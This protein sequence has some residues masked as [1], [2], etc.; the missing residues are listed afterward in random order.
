M[1]GFEGNT[2]DQG[3]SK[4]A[5]DAFRGV[6]CPALDRFS[7]GLEDQGG[8]GFPLPRSL[9]AR[10]VKER[11]GQSEKI[12]STVHALTSNHLGGGIKKCAACGVSQRATV[13]P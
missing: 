7:S 1:R 6:V 13:P 9:G 8:L 10:Q 4:G 3:S 12:A 5:R 2:R 11:G